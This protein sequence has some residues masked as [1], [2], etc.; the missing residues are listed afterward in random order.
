MTLKQ[1]ARRGALALLMLAIIAPAHAHRA[2]MLPS[3]TVLSGDSAWLTVDAAISNSLFYFEHHAM[4][5]SG[6]EIIGPQQ[7]S[8]EAVNQA[9]GRYRSVFDVELSQQGTYTLQI[10]NQGVFASYEMNGEQKRWRGTAEQLKDIP[11]AASNVK[12]RE[13]DRRMQTF[14]SLGAPTTNTFNSSGVGLEM[15]PITH[16]NDLF[17]GETAQFRFLMDGKP[18]TD[19]NVVL[20]RAGIRYRDQVNAMNLTTNNLGEISVDWPEAGMYWLEV[21]TQQPGKNVEGATRSLGY[22]ATLEVLP[23]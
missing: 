1:L 8:L 18:A 5:L 16:P 12:I 21:E 7:Q 17:A 19:L 13:I 15:Q 10:H 23:L 4:N 20:I 11:A 14:A 2:W 6:L 3:A 22:S 9:R